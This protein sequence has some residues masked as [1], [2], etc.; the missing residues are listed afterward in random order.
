MK[1]VSLKIKE[2]LFQKVYNFSDKCLIY[3]DENSRGKT[4]LLRMLLFALGYNIPPTKKISFSK[5][6]FE[7]LC[8]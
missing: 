4:T 8:D 1:F 6:V 5:Y 7:L 2:G 3:S